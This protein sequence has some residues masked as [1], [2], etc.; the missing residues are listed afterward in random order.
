[1]TFSHPR[2]SALKRM[3]MLPTLDIALVISVFLRKD[4]MGRSAGS[5]SQQDIIFPACTKAF[6]LVSNGG[7]PS[8]HLEKSYCQLGLSVKADGSQV[9]EN[10]DRALA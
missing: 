8:R 5:N 6:G 7:N 10:L 4:D 9:N 3:Q 2:K 1:M